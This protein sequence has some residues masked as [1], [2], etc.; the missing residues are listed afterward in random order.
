MNPFRYVGALGYYYDA[1][2]NRYYVRARHYDPFLGRWMSQDPV[3]SSGNGYAYG[4]NNPITYVDP[5]GKQTK[6]RPIIPLPG[7]PMQWFPGWD[8]LPLWPITPWH[9]KYCPV[10]CE[11][12][13]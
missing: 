3:P 4:L 10:T 12:T 5:S 9:Q 8:F 11:M 7:P 1:F 13:W 2:W 6:L